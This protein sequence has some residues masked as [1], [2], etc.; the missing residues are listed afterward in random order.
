[1]DERKERG[2]GRDVGMREG[3]GSNFSKTLVVLSHPG[4]VDP[5]PALAWTEEWLFLSTP[6]PH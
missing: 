6:H 4:E 2:E 5:L 1:M 3:D